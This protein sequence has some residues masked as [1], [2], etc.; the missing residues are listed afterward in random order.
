MLFDFYL[1]LLPIL[2]GT[3]CF[4]SLCL[5]NYVLHTSEYLLLGRDPVEPKAFEGGLAMKEGLIVSMASSPAGAGMEREQR[6]FREL[7]FGLWS[8]EQVIFIR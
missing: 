7:L 1:E 3:G 8:Y 6:L 5:H 4:H 2:L